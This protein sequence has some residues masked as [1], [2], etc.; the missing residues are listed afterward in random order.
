[1]IRGFEMGDRRMAEIRTSDGSLYV[2]THWNGSELFELAKAAV[3]AAKPRLHDEPYWTRI[4][5][6]QMTKDGRDEETGWGLMLKPSA[7]DEY[8]GDKPSVIIDA[9]DGTVTE[10][11]RGDR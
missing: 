8:N 5:V 7:E 1:M 4:V 11:T 9:S 6:D 3:E 2:Y 10:V